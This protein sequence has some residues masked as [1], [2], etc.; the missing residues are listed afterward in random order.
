MYVQFSIS[1]N[2]IYLCVLIGIGIIYVYTSYATRITCF[3]LN[4]NVLVKTMK[5]NIR[6]HVTEK[7][8]LFIFMLLLND[9]MGDRQ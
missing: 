4:V 9:S 6:T 8:F 3:D 5:G 7:R 1:S 2:E